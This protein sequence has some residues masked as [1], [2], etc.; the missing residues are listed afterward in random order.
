MSNRLLPRA[1]RWLLAR[2][3][4][5][6]LVLAVLAGCSGDKTTKNKISGTVKVGDKNASGTVAFVGSDGKEYESPITDGKYKINKIPTGEYKVLVKGAAGLGG[7][8]V[9]VESPE[10][11]NMP[12]TT[13]GE[14]PHARYAKADNG[15]PTL[16]VAGGD[17]EHNIELKP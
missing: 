13:M 3:L 5:L 8:P 17:Q 10:I 6:V 2:Q 16:T 11:P 4:A 1:S 7:P 9:K 12:K 14:A 15:L